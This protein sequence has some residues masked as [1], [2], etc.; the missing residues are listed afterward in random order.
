VQHIC[1]GADYIRF[2][3]KSNQSKTDSIHHF[4]KRMILSVSSIQ[5][6]YQP[7][8]LCFSCVTVMILIYF[9]LEEVNLMR[10]SKL[11]T[12]MMRICFF[13]LFLVN[14]INSF[15]NVI[16]VVGLVMLVD[17]KLADYSPDGLN[18]RLNVLTAS[19]GGVPAAAILI[20]PSGTISTNKP[21]YSWNAVP[22]AAY[23]Y[24]YN[25][26]DFAWHSASEAGCSAGT[27]ICSVTG[28]AL[29]AGSYTWYVRT[30]NSS[31]YGPWSSGM[32]FS[33]SAGDTPVAATLI[34]PFGT[35]STVTPTYTWNA[36]SNV[37]Y[38]YLWNGAAFT[39]HSASEAG[40]S[41]G[42]GI[43][44]ITGAALV[45]G[46]YTWYVRTWNSSGYGPW[47]SGMAF[48]ISAGGAT[49]TTYYIRPDGGTSEQCTGGADAPYSGSGA[50]GSCTVSGISGAT[51]HEKTLLE[52][53]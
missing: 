20:S 24:F 25:G 35:I 21:A 30:W 41:A 31:G 10:T 48:T 5:I 33:I 17:I 51:W 32:G 2:R 37:S 23:Y 4:Q 26:V 16:P 18:E 3:R 19:S 11:S 1:S 8:N 13:L 36:V 39:W 6:I 45:A 38:Y 29:A 49:G 43:C 47:S 27:G 42:T 7:G 12:V 14:P 44:S 22:N 15:A 52:W 40:C 9:T 50:G 34:S 28:A 53:K 46:S